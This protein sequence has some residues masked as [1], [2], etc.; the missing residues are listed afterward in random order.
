MSNAADLL[1]VKLSILKLTDT[2]AFNRQL[3]AIGTEVLRRESGGTAANVIGITSLKDRKAKQE[4]F[5]QAELSK[6]LK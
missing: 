5:I 2:A 3:L 1:M 4:A 6:R